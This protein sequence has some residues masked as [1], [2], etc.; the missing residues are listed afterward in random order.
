MKALIKPL[1]VAFSLTLVSLSSSFANAAVSPSKADSTVAA[2]YKSGMYTTTEGKLNI[3]IEKQTSGTVEIRMTNSA[4]KEL[5]AQR[6]GKRQ[7]IARLRLD[8]SALPD[9][10]YQVSIS[11]GVDTTVNNITLATQQPS[12]AARQIALN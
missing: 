11:N 8:V 5:F 10:V 7:K 9:G 2:A 6:V 3:A 12:L 1:L 4:G